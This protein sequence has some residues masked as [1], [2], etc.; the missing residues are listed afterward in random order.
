VAPVATEDRLRRRI[1]RELRRIVY[2]RF[3]AYPGDAK[4]PL[5]LV[6]EVHLNRTPV[7]VFDLEI[8]IPADYPSLVPIVFETGERI[9]R[10]DDPWHV[11]SDG[12]LCLG[13]NIQVSRR[14]AADETIPGL[15]E[16]LVLPYLAGFL[17]RDECGVPPQGELAHG[18]RGILDD[19]ARLLAMGSP[20]AI[21]ACLLMIRSRRI[22]GHLPCP[23]GSGH[24]LKRCHGWRLHAMANLMSPALFQRDI[25]IIHH[26]L[27]PRAGSIR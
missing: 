20:T 27:A 21:L 6:G 22:R 2:G 24:K 10:G 18:G 5:F 19:Y 4:H 16:N 25:D 13:S 26:A 12:S 3:D 14:F 1:G 11:N 8:A 15:L 17:D 23:C 9:P 7:E